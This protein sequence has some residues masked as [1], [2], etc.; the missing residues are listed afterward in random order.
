M[1]NGARGA[2]LTAVRPKHEMLAANSAAATESS[3]A[4]SILRSQNQIMIESLIG[5]L[6]RYIESLG[7][8]TAVL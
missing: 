6:R 3:A 1:Q 8:K 2:P 5:S 7:M 4:A